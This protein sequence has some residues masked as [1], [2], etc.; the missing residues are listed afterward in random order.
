MKKLIK[1]LL[2]EKTRNRI[3]IYSTQLKTHKLT[4]IRNTFS[5]NKKQESPYRSVVDYNNL[6]NELGEKYKPT[7]RLHNYLPHYWKHFRDIHK[8]VTRVLEIGVESDKSIK[9]WE[10]F[11]P[12]A[13]VYGI[14]I[15]PKCADFAGNRRKIFIGDQSD[16][17]FLHKV[18]ED[19]GGYFDIIIDD[20]S[21]WTRHQL[22]SFDI[23]F[24]YLS[25]H[26]VYV[27]EDTGAV[28]GDT[29]L[30]TVNAIKQLVDNIMYFP[31][32]VEF[33]SWDQYKTFPENAGWADK[34]IV[35]I[36]FYRWLCFIEKGNNPGDNPYILNDAGK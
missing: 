18:L 29:K 25:S 32:G 34:N 1:A 10:E 6:L 19:A 7:K 33:S 2:P 13:L 31:P 36:A 3:A 12:N 23:L 4:F 21:H 17:T 24:P 11:F 8:K 30:K 27:I 35:G 20:G 28:V 16:E 14:D 5:F 15:N 26:G 9:M 22:K